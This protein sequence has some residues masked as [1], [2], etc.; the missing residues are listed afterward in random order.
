MYICIYVHILRTCAVHKAYSQTRLKKGETMNKKLLLQL[1]AEGDPKTFTQEELDKIINERLAREK[2]AY[3]K[4][5]EDMTLEHKKELANYSGDEKEKEL[6]KLNLEEQEKQ[7]ARLM[8]EVAKFRKESRKS[9]ILTAY[10]KD[11]MPCVD[12]FS[13]IVSLVSNIEDDSE[14]AEVYSAVK[15]YANAIVNKVKQDSLKR[16]EPN[17]NSSTNTSSENNPFKTGNFTEITRLV[18]T[19]KEKA[20]ELA[21]ASGN[22]EK[23]SY[24]F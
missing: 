10:S 13:K 5:I 7:N 22:F 3:E 4:Q 8:E 9:E 11:E 19:D 24:L 15:A 23:Y 20:K 17:G 18:R 6:L 14:R 1:F 2:K 16:E 21:S 12:E